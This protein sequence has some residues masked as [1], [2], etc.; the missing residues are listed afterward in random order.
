MAPWPIYTGSEANLDRY[1]PTAT[2]GP[3]SRDIAAQL[4]ELSE[5]R[6]VCGRQ[7]DNFA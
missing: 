5:N 1:T 6:I 4:D 2:R 7:L 3:P